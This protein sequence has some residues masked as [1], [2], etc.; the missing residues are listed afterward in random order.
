MFRLTLS[1]LPLTSCLRRFGLITSRKRGRSPNR[2][3]GP[4]KVR[5]TLWSY[6]EVAQFR[7][8]RDGVC[9]YVTYSLGGRDDLTPSMPGSEG[10]KGEQLRQRSKVPRR[11]DDAD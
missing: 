7:F 8:L 1:P 10:G 2:I 3:G 11:R 5:R 4:K 9:V 6:Y